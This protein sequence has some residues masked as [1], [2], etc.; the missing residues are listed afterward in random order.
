MKPILNKNTKQTFFGTFN[1]LHKL[2]DYY[3]TI[4]A[5]DQKEAG[6]LMYKSFGGNWN[7]IISDKF[8]S[9]LFC[10]GSYK[11]LRSKR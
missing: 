9:K 10:N 5:K 4:I 2:K 3:I 11:L 6:L 7:R 8:D 1:Q